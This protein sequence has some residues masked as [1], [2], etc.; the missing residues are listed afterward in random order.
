[1]NFSRQDFGAL[2]PPKRYEHL[3]GPLTSQTLK[4]FVGPAKEHLISF[5]AVYVNKD[6]I[7]DPNFEVQSVDIIRIH[8]E[9]KRYQVSQADL[10]ERVIFENE[11]FLIL[12]KPSG[13][14]MHPTL[15]NYYENLVKGVES[16]VK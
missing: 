16:F 6:R 10:Q 7:L 5:G 3:Q 4:D 12:N 15:D 11:N 13:L 2:S 8:L 1:M 14:P 9:P